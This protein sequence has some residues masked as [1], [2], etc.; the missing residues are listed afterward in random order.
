[1]TTPCLTRA[2][3]AATRR[4]SSAKPTSAAIPS[5][6]STKSKKRGCVA[7]NDRSKAFSDA[8]SGGLGKTPWV[9]A[10]ARMKT[11]MVASKTASTAKDAATAGYDEFVIDVFVR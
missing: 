10:K 4:E 8:K 2:Q 11:P 1:M 5:A 9:K 3:K 7:K 6:V